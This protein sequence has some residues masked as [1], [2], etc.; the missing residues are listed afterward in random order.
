MNK[1]IGF[2][3][4]IFLLTN[5]IF[6]QER[7]K[8][9]S[10]S[11][12]GGLTM[13]N[14]YGE[15]AESE[16]FLNGD[17]PETFYANNPASTNLRSGI[18]IGSLLEYRFNRRFSLGVGINYIQKGSGIKANQHWSSSNQDYENVE[19]KIKWRQNYLTLDVP[20]KVYFPITKNEFFLQGGPSFGHLL[21][22]EEKGTVEVSGNEYDYTHDGGANKNE[23][24]FLLG[25]GYS[26]LL[27][28]K[29]DSLILEFIWNRSFGKSYGSDMIGNSQKY[30]NQTFS[31]NIGYAFKFNQNKK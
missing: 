16:T 5:L 18:N 15:D 22:S 10:I 24:G 29:K 19:A 14:Q 27:P 31:L 4:L 17:S 8:G 2:L 28:N 9:L 6:A 11:L 23:V 13:A 12:K 20:L 26:Y 3:L 30:Y 21:Y 25:F 1:S 7:H